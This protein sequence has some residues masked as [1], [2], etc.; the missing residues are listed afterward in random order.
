[1]SIPA[2]S[3]ILIVSL[4][5]RLRNARGLPDW[6]NTTNNDRFW[7]FSDLAN[8]LSVRL[9]SGAKRTS[10]SRSRRVIIDH[11]LLWLFPHAGGVRGR[12]CRQFGGDAAPFPQRRSWGS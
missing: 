8:E 11:Q 7:P 9:L 3:G 10:P 12:I 5:Q 4:A 6:V 2:H 1:M